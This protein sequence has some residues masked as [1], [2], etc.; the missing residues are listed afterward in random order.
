MSAI[1]LEAEVRVDLGKGSSRRLR[2]LEQKIP[3]VVYGGD[4][5][6]QSIHLAHHKVVKA[7]ETESIFS[8]VLN[9]KI[10]GKVE[11]VILK[12]MQRHPFKP[13]IMHMDLQRVSAKDVLVKMIPLHFTHETEAKGVKAGGMVS[14]TMT[15][16]EVKCQVKDLPEFIE[17]DLIDMELNDVIHLS[18]I[19]LPKGVK[20]AVDPTEGDHDHPV[21]SIHLNRVQVEEEP[22]VED[23][24]EEEEAAAA[25]D[26]ETP[27]DE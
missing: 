7:L 17:V 18:S 24:E 6:A 26:S 2:R 10:N 13:I 5:A 19:K 16:V 27:T 8:S 4:K 23:E 20:F 15:Q 21:V 25:P 12:A 3:A 22:V 1:Q 9:L 11:H 14:H